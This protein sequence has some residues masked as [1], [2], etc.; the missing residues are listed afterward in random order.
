MQWE[1][2]I[3]KQDCWGLTDS[4]GKIGRLKRFWWQC[5]SCQMRRLAPNQVLRKISH[6]N[7]A[8]KLHFTFLTPA[9][10]CHVIGSLII[11][12]WGAFPRP[13]EEYRSLLPSAGVT[14][15][16]IPKT[17]QLAAVKFPFVGN[18]GIPKTRS[19]TTNEVLCWRRFVA[20]PP[21]VLSSAKSDV[22]SGRR[23]DTN[24]GG[25]L[26]IKWWLKKKPQCLNQF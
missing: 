13:Q 20:I 8:S 2:W 18:F 5:E 9:L 11:R 26:I 15:L 3:K 22:S 4:L 12:C 6:P 1:Q 16:H 19:T 25:D 10:G 23:K 17:W 7:I 24:L 21:G 14:G